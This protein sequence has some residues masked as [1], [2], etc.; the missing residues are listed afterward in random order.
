MKVEAA[1]TS[2]TNKPPAIK[3]P[4]TTMY[5]PRTAGRNYTNWKLK[6]A[7]Y[8]LSR[9]IK[10]KLKVL[11]PQLA[12]GGVIIPDGNLQDHVRYAKDKGRP[13]H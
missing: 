12:S 9:S 6:P 7:K 10:A 13:E 4:P 1:F 3:P 8:A 2:A 11:D 5:P